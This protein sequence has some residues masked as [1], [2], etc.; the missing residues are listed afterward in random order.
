MEKP[1]WLRLLLGFGIVFA[2]VAGM[3]TWT[4]SRSR[5][6]I[7]ETELIELRREIMDGRHPDPESLR[8]GGLF[9]E[10][11]FDYLMTKRRLALA[12]RK[13]WCNQGAQP[14]VPQAPEFLRP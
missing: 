3:S 4:I 9:P 8:R 2:I 12:R 7:R 13:P 5:S 6:R 10:K 14:A 1:L 11:E